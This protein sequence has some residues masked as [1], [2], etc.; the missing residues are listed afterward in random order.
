M[1]LNVVLCWCTG[2]EL[3]SAHVGIVVGM[4]MRKRPNKIQLATN[5]TGPGLL[6][7]VQP[8]LLPYTP[9]Y[10][11]FTTGLTRSKK[12]SILEIRIISGLEQRT[13]VFND[14]IT[15]FLVF[16]RDLP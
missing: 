16:Y 14:L 7:P 11:A 15:V 8:A 4:R 1:D 6:G 5:Q 3:V 9:S 2:S 12:L 13:Q 10:S